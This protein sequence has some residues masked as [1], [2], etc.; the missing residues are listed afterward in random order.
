MELAYIKGFTPAIVDLSLAALI[1]V[2]LGNLPA[3]TIVVIVTGV[4]V[5]AVLALFTIV[6]VVVTGDD[7]VVVAVVRRD[8]RVSSLIM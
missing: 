2:A 5:Y 7:V 6:V 1:A 8:E 3:Q 4:F